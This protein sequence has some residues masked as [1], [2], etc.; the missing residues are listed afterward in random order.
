[1][2]EDGAVIGTRQATWETKSKSYLG[3]IPPVGIIL[4]PPKEG[5]KDEEKPVA[6]KVSLG[7]FSQLGELLQELIGSSQTEKADLVTSVEQSNAT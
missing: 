7:D 4:S 3:E 2:A 5:E 6:V 1:M